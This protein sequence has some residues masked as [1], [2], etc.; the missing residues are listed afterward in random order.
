VGKNA[1]EKKR[2]DDY[3]LSK[4]LA[5]AYD[6]GVDFNDTNDHVVLLTTRLFE[7]KV[8]C[9]FKE[10]G[11]ILAHEVAHLKR[12]HMETLKKLKIE[13][14]HPWWKV[15]KEKYRGTCP[16]TGKDEQAACFKAKVFSKFVEE[17]P[18]IAARSREHENEA[19]AYGN[20]YMTQVNQMYSKEDGQKALMRIKEYEKRENIPSSDMYDS[21]DVR[22]TLL[23]R[24]F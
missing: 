1:A 3:G 20:H 14:F 5:A 15:N 9:N 10:L 18:A 13:G 17:T 24:G 22:S 2:L 23:N 19:D 12:D 16:E 7:D 21:E 11:F 8:A 6:P 4:A